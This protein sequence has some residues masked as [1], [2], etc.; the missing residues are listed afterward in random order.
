MAPTYPDERFLALVLTRLEIGTES[1]YNSILAF[2]MGSTEF[3]APDRIDVPNATTQNECTGSN[4]MTE[5]EQAELEQCQQEAQDVNDCRESCTEDY[6]ESYCRIF[7]C[8]SISSRCENASAG[9]PD[10]M[11]SGLTFSDIGDNNCN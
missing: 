2:G 9:S 3:S 8:D 6:S 10:D 1:K 4:P 5:E 11:F 7:V